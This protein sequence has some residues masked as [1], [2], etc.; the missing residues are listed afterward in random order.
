MA[1]RVR[2][3]IDL[4]ELTLREACA[5]APSQEAH[6]LSTLPAIIDAFPHQFAS[7]DAYWDLRVID[8]EMLLDWLRAQGETDG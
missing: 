5:A 1:E 2:V 8:H 4:A 6:Y 3:E 7:V